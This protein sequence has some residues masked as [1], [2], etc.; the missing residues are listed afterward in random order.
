LYLSHHYA[1]DL[2]GG[3][4]RTPRA[5]NFLPRVV[6]VLT[7]ARLIAVA[8]LVFYVAKSKFLARLQADKDLR[9][10]YDYTE[11]GDAPVGDGYHLGDIDLDFLPGISDGDEWTVGSSSSISS[12][13]ISPVDES[14]SLWEGETLASHSDSE[15]IDVVI[16]GR[17]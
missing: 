6:S 1:V 4:L 11:I 5:F 14:Q 8:G 9:W 7:R 17:R 10:D 15:V 2:I 12:G 16:D 13:S 3:S